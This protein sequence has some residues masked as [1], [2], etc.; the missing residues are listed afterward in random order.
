MIDIIIPLALDRN[1]YELLMTLRSIEKNLT[2]Y[3]DIYLI[4]EKP[5]WAQNVIHVPMRDLHGR[6]QYSIFL[7]V[8]RAAE[9]ESVSRFFI[10]WDDD[11]YLLQSLHVN[12]FKHWCSGTLAEWAVKNINTLYRSVVKNTLNLFPNG[13]YYD[14]HPPHVYEKE[15]YLSLDTE[16]WRRT[17]LLTKSYY[18][19]NVDSEPVQMEDPKKK[20][21][22]FYSTA[23]RIHSD[24]QKMLREMFK[25]PSKYEL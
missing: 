20:K 4:G 12:D 10:R 25:L 2:G 9:M 6:K 21:G 5:R 24:E 3:R 13:L 17:E 7:K 11:C 8:M 19:N 14:I 16:K 15:K 22:L 18:F 23:S 1:Y